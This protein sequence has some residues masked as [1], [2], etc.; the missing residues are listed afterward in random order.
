[1]AIDHAIQH[2]AEERA[3]ALPPLL[4]AAERVAST[5]AQG[6]HG[7]RRVGQGDSFWQ[8]RPYAAGEAIHRIDLRET[9]KSDRAFVRGNEREAA[10]SVWL[11]N[12]RSPSLDYR[13]S[14]D[15]SSQ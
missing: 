5:V 4:V 2:R 9:A 14:R 6:V 7:R 3:G 10:Q 8:F 15:L 13:S 11:W 12:D 1:M